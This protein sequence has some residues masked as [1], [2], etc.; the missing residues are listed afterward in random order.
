LVFASGMGW[1]PRACATLAK[2]QVRV[3]GIERGI[4]TAGAP[5][6]PRL[7]QD[8]ADAAPASAANNR[9]MP[10]WLS[11]VASRMASPSTAETWMFL[12]A[13]R[14]SMVNPTAQET[15]HRR[16]RAERARRERRQRYG[17]ERS[18]GI[19]L[20]QQPPAPVDEQRIAGGRSPG[21]ARGCRSVAPFRGSRPHAHGSPPS[22]SRA[23]PPTSTIRETTQ[24]VEHPLPSTAMA[25]KDGTSRPP[26]QQE[27][28]VRHR[29]DVRQARQLAG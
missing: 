13:L 1:E 8:G 4:E 20:R 28:E 18:R 6:A 27:I 14:K 11:K 15:R 19:A 25:S 26:V 21:S 7:G 2:H 17:I 22:S 29:R 10:T 23:N 5:I 16:R 12:D 3:V 24:G 9:T